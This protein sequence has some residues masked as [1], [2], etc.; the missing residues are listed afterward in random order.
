[1]SLLLLIQVDYTKKKKQLKNKSKKDAVQSFEYLPASLRHFT[2]PRYWKI[3][4]SKWLRLIF[5]K[6]V[7]RLESKSSKRYEKIRKTPWSQ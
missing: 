4:I 1:M 7:I 6:T 5:P 3:N 2:F